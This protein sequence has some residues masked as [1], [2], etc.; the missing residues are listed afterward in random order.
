MEALIG[1]IHKSTSA[2][3]EVN[4]GALPHRQRRRPEDLALWIIVFP[5]CTPVNGEGN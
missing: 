5:R 1:T 2:R 3:R 4:I